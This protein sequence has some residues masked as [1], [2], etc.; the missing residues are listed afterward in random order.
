MSRLLKWT[1]LQNDFTFLIVFKINHP[2]CDIFFHFNRRDARGAVLC[3]SSPAESGS[4]VPGWEYNRLHQRRDEN[5]KQLSDIQVRNLTGSDNQ[6]KN[7]NKHHHIKC[8]VFVFLLCPQPGNVRPWQ[9]S[10]KRWK[11][12][13]AHTSI[14]RVASTWALGHLIWWELWKPYSDT[15]GLLKMYFC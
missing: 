14:L 1:F 7:K 13:A 4:H 9:I 2:I 8:F 5:A 11:I 6:T 15:V 10:Q 12:R 3:W